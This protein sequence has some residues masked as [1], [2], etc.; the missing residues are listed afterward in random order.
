MANLTTDA[1]WRSVAWLV[2][3]CSGFRLPEEPERQ[4]EERKRERKKRG[5]GRERER[6]LGG[7]GGS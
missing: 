7:R 4:K 2:C 3:R 1:T 5:R 6:A